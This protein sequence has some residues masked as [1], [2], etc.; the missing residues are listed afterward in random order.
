MKNFEIT[1]ALAD[2]AAD[3]GVE[4]NEEF[5]ALP[6]RIDRAE[7]LLIAALSLGNQAAADRMSAVIA[8]LPH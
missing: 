3:L 4:N 5:L 6:R 2:A 7:W 8:A 1:A